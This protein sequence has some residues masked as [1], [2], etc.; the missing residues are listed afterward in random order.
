MVHK[1]TNTVQMLVTDGLNPRLLPDGNL[2]QLKQ[3]QKEGW[4]IPQWSSADPTSDISNYSEEPFLRS[5][6]QTER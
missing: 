1:D 5:V 4:S 2:G 3:Q 6:K